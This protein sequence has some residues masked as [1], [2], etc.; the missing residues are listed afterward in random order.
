M[1]SGGDTFRPFRSAVGGSAVILLIGLGLRWHAR[2]G[3]VGWVAEDSFEA[4]LAAVALA[5]ACLITSDT[6]SLY[7]SAN[8]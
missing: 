1:A 5:P 6:H 4:A 8:V 3:D 7:V 2:A